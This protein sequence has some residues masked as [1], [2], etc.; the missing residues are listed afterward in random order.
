VG[1]T[2]AE[3]AIEKSALDEAR[4]A[5]PP[6]REVKLGRGAILYLRPQLSGRWMADVRWPDGRER[7]A[8]LAAGGWRNGYAATEEEAE[9]LGRELHAEGPRRGGEA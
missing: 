3:R 2:P 5:L 6:V 4:A 9:A 7:D 8:E 1:A